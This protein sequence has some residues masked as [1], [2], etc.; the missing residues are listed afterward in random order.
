MNSTL[1]A[2]AAYVLAQLGI[3]WYISRRIRTEDDYLVAGRSLGYGVATFTLFATW[4]GAETCIGAAGRIYR[5]GLSGGSADPFG[6]AI[7]LFAMGLFIAV[8]LWRLRL[9]TLADLFSRRYSRGVERFAVLLMVPTSIL[10]AAAQ[11]RA[12]GQVISA[13]SGLAVDLTITL[14]AAVVILYTMY[15]GLLAD[16]WTDVI[17][18]GALMIGLV[19]F[20]IVF[21][22]DVGFEGLSTMSPGRLNPFGGEE[23][24]LLSIIER[25][26]IP[27]CGSLMAAELAS[28]IIAA[29]SPQVAQRSSLMAGGIYL[30]FGLIP[31][32]IGLLGAPL[33]PSLGDP[34]HFLPLMAQRYLPGIVYA[35][36]A[37]ALVSAILSTVDSA[38]LAASSLVSHNVVVPLRP[39]MPERTKV[40]IAR[41]GVALFGVI[42]YVL[43]LH[44]EG[45]YALVEEA[46]SF[47]SAGIF[48]VV[49][50]GLF[51]RF[52]GAM[53]ATASLAAG[54]I[55]WILG[56]YIFDFPLP[57]LTSLAAAFGAYVL[58]ALIE[59]DVQ[60]TAEKK[61]EC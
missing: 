13:S 16:A 60:D 23:T 18:G 7:C 45:V 15:G 32:T 21:I 14:A 4:F 52:G 57:Y 50:F 2:I 42:A 6:Y 56:A 48:A 44:A 27:I 12:F 17:Q 34:E 31:V 10:W 24:G 55:A 3:G 38:L 33:M 51:S 36:F 5:D 43:A 39:D 59:G 61:S 20:F 37:G 35:L 1:V 54:V 25:W 22:S 11:V 30:L 9:T 53:S 19:V 26:A 41:I 49:L 28:R 29:R 58:T 40:R 8:P 47:G 46:S